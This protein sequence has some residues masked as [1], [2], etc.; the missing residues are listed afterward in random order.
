VVQNADTWKELLE[1]HRDE[2]NKV[3]EDERR[4]LQKF[5]NFCMAKVLHV[6]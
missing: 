1:N 2:L 3:S 6:R 5:V 4:I